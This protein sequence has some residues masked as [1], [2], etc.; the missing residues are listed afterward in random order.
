VLKSAE[1]GLYQNPWLA[2]ANRAGETVAKLAAAMGLDPTSRSR[3]TASRPTT[4]NEMPT[5]PRTKFR[6]RG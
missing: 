2:V 3:V 5:R 1:G 6:D 4:E